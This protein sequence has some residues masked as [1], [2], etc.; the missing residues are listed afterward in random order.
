MKILFTRFPLESADGGAENQTQWLTE[1]LRA[2]GYEVS[3]V[4]SCPVLLRR[5][6]ECKMK[7]VECR[8][9]PPPVTKWSAISFFWRRHVMKKALM[10]AIDALSEKPDAIFMLSLSEKLLMS[11]ELAARGIRIFWVEHDRIGPWL[12]L[13]PWLGALKRAAEHA[14]I[15]CVSAV[16]R[17]LYLK[18][19]FDPEKVISIPNGVPPS[20][21]PFPREGRNAG[22]VRVGTVARLDP[23]K[24]I[25][26]LIQSV[27]HLPEV[28]LSIL[29]T[30]REEAYLRSLIAAD[31]ERMG[32]ERIHLISRVDDLAAF[33]RSLDIFVLPSS[34]HDPFGLVAAEAMMQG[35]ATI[36]TDACGISGSL[37]AHEEAL[38]VPAGDPKKLSMAIGSLLDV[39]RRDRLAKAGMQAARERLSVSTM[40]DRYD[41]LL[42]SQRID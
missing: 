10:R 28:T 1:G 16:S 13:N 36:V 7:N 26:V 37:K 22:E 35:V 17:A 24:G 40:V 4:G 19:G 12:S 30:G 5:A 25:D 31:T 3:F 2:R 32:Q 27:E 9:G 6:R 34:D 18:M 8:I 15:V 14:T 23:E 42:R 21:D 33:Y 20:P 41:R 11:E 29:G 38:I 39:P